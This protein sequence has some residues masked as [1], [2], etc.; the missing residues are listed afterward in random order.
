[1][2]INLL[3]SFALHARTDLADVRAGM[4]CG[5]LLV[6]SGAFSAHNSG[7]TI[8]LEEYAEYLERWRGVWDYAIT[9]DRIGDPDATRKQ[10]RR[11]HARGLPVMPVFT[12]GGKLAEFEA[13]AREHRYVA[14]GGTVGMGNRNPRLL[15]QRLRVLQRRAEAHGGGIHALGCG[16]IEA[17][18]LAR[19]YSAD[20]STADSIGKYGNVLIFDG[21]RLRQL[22]VGGADGRAHL[23]RYRDVLAAHGYDVAL[24]ARTGRVS[25][26][27]QQRVVNA[28]AYAVADEVLGRLRVP[29]PVA[30]AR[31]GTVLYIAPARAARTDPLAQLDARLHEGPH[32]RVWL[33]YGGRRHV[34]HRSGSGSAFAGLPSAGQGV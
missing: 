25:S 16:S 32:P 26:H 34:C 12:V 33:Q 13:M 22:H 2:A 18:R 11:L 17:L 30:G 9:L 27:P 21:E 7:R 14:V 19:P 24:I 8:A 23:T 4:R 5:S 29:P 10:T 6:D 28:V 20:T 31:R 15:G 3:L 1:M